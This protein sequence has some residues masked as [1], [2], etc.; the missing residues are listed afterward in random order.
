M[1]ADAR[2][3]LEFGKECFKIRH[4]DIIRHRFYCDD[5]VFLIILGG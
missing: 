3:N 1:I 2:H 5:H 4:V